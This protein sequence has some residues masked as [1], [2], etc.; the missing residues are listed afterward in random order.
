MVAKATIWEVPWDAE[1]SYTLLNHLPND[2]QIAGQARN[3]VNVATVVIVTGEDACDIRGRRRLRHKLVLKQAEV[4]QPLHK[5]LTVKAMTVSREAC[6]RDA[7]G[8][9][10]A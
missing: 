7:A 2:S 10:R 4:A 8:L 9:V 3:D 6:K 5:R 1:P